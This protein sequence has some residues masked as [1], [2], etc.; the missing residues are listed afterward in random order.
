MK[1]GLPDPGSDRRRIL[2]VAEDA[3]RIADLAKE[4]QRN[5]LELG[6]QSLKLQGTLEALEAANEEL[7][8]TT[9]QIASAQTIA[10][11]A[12]ARLARLQSITAA[13]SNTVTQDDV[14]ESVLREA[15]VALECEAGAVV[16]STGE[17][18]ERLV[19]LRE[20]GSLDPIMRSFTHPRP[21][22]SRGPYFDAVEN[23][24]PIYL[25]TFDE[26]RTRYPAFQ[27]ASK[28]DSHGAWIFLPLE[29]G[30]NAVGAMAFGFASSRSFT[31][32]DAHF[33][34]TVSRYCAQALD[35]VRLRDAAASALAVA[36]EARMMSEH[37]N[38]AKT[39]FLRSI[40]H[41]LRTPLHAIAGFTEVLELGIRGAVNP[42][43]SKDLARIKRAAAF[44]LRLINDVLAIAKIEGST[45]LQL[46]SLAVNPVLAEVEGLC[47]LQAKA[48]SL[49]L[50]LTPYE[51]DI[52]V[53]AD[54][55]RFQQILLNLVTNAIKFTPNGGSIDVTCDADASM[56]R[57]R[58]TDTGIGVRQL[59][60]DRVF[61]PFVQINRHLTTAT[62][63]GAGL[64]L[65]ISR[66][67]ARA[68]HGDLTLESIE[69]V[70]SRFT[71]TLPVGQEA[72]PFVS[73]TTT[74]RSSATR[75]PVMR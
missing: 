54:A 69:G 59:D 31:L 47:G 17:E 36:R 14:A 8:R 15:I 49:T 53:T 40:S 74:P 2:A 16:V 68:M 65:S 10:D 67:L 1:N 28:S 56:V 55:D 3:I 44:L 9:A 39:L 27:Q 61:E 4:L 11:A 41:E 70:E 21:N 37:A 7:D 63:Q 43:Q 38:N 12:T 34:E 32:L 50:T 75:A 18:P 58:V 23:A 71:L 57:V 33:A 24:G 22:E 29:I 52:F 42:E 19:L 46:V 20:A 6:G 64:G 13:L 5:A 35:R 66:E 72:T 25:E 60:L 73:M 51:R 26:M 30:G 62:Q 48:K 45:P